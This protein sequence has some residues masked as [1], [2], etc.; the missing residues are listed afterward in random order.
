MRELAYRREQWIT[1]QRTMTSKHDGL[2]SQ[3]LRIVDLN[4]GKSTMKRMQI[5]RDDFNSAIL[6]L[7]GKQLTHL[8]R[9]R[10]LSWF[11][12][13]ST[14]NNF[15]W[16]FESQTCHCATSACATH[17]AGVLRDKIR[18]FLWENKFFVSVLRLFGFLLMFRRFIVGLL[19]SYKSIR[20]D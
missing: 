14:N 15:F 16:P 19:K 11:Y 20:L 1:S 2:K 9:S 7:N 5:R 13:F 12:Q 4:S 18:H 10:C 8:Y 6:D 17:S 3:Y